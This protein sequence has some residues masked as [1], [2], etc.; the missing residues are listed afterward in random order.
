MKFEDGQGI[1]D[2]DY[3]V[4]VR[5]SATSVCVNVSVPSLKGPFILRVCTFSGGKRTFVKV[6]IFYYDLNKL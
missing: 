2:T 4:Y 5:S 6:Y 1:P 3:I